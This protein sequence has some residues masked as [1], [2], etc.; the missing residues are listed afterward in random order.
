MTGRATVPCDGCTACC[1]HHELIALHPDKGDI[2][3]LYLTERVTNPLTG[4]TVLAI[5]RNAD[6]SCV[7]V[8]PQGCTIHDRAPVICR[9]FD[10]GLFWASLPRH[11]RKQLVAA[12]GAHADVMA[13]GKRVQQLRKEGRA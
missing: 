2:P 12:D 7:Y 11:A 10:C 9:R 1:R 5:Q 13:A 6:G 8:G 4:Q 3:A